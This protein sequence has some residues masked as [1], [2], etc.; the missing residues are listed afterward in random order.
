MF[1]LDDEKLI[2]Q[3]SKNKQETIKLSEMFGKV[4]E[5]IDCSRF[6]FETVQNHEKTIE[7]PNNAS[8][9]SFKNGVLHEKKVVNVEKIEFTGGSLSLSDD[10]KTNS[11]IVFPK[12]RP[13]VGQGLG[14]LNGRFQF[15]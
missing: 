11:Q 4:A 2:V 1:V 3:I 12:K 10:M 13:G 6:D 8:L 9:L 5:R 15:C 14:F 7:F